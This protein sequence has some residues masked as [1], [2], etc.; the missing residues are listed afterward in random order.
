VNN[1][2]GHYWG[3]AT[4]NNLAAM[5]QNPRDLKGPRGWSPRDARRR[6]AVWDKYIKGDTA[7]AARSQDERTNT[8]KSSN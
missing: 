3:C 1:R 7:G 8:Q 5:M 4:Q 2:N 6:D